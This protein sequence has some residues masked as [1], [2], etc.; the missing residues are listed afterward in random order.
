[1]DGRQCDI[2][3]IVDI[4]DDWVSIGFKACAATSTTD[5]TAL[6]YA[7]LY[8]KI[9]IVEFLLEKGAGEY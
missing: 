3:A 6:H 7:A 5:V 4:R 9:D 2:N 1:M 8:G